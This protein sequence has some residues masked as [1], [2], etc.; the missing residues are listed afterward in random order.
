[1]KTNWNPIAILVLSAALTG[2]GDKPAPQPSAPAPAIDLGSSSDSETPAATTPAATTEPEAKKDE[3][4]KAPTEDKASTDA[5]KTESP[6]ADD[7]AKSN[8]PNV[9]DS[10]VALSPKT[11]AVGGL[12]DPTAETLKLIKTMQVK[13]G[14][15]P[16]WGGSQFRNNVPDGKGIATEWN[17]EDGTNIK[18]AAKLGS[19]TYGNP[20]VANGKVYIGTNNGSGYLKRYPSKVDLGCLLCFDE[21]T[22]E[23]LWQHSSEKL[24]SGR[25]ND[26]PNQGIC[27]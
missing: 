2:C 27:S 18:W 23:F 13:P 4:D 15:W 10:E 26:W 22:G 24:A 6:K 8:P 9:N 21:E 14:D 16:Q 20:V 19:E 25:V 1:M 11:S 12:F 5:P 3:E 7:E 17:V